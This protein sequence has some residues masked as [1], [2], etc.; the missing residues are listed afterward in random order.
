M[1]MNGYRQPPRSPKE[2]TF[3]RLTTC[4]SADMTSQVTPCQFGGKP[5]C[6][7][8]GCM[9]SAGLHAFATVK[10]GGLIPLSGILNASLRVGGR[11]ANGAMTPAC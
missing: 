4:V 10:L 3:A 1:V 8:C 7:E 6:G 5:V 9:A 2:C 11:A